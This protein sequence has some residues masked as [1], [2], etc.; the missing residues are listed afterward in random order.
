MSL[1][2]DTWMVVPATVVPHVALHI[3]VHTYR[4]NYPRW[5]PSDL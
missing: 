2:K 4:P 1:L 3:S 5:L